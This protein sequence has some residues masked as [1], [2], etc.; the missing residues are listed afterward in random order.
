[1]KLSVVI[2]GYN[3]PEIWWRRCVKSVLVACSAEDEVICVDDGSLKKPM[4]LHDIAKSDSRVKVIMLPSNMGQSEA[5][6]AGLR[7]ANGTYVTFVDSDDSVEP[8]VY[9]RALNKIQKTSSD[10]VVFGARTIWV[11]ER[12]TKVDVPLE[13]DYG[14]VKPSDLKQLIDGCLFEYVWN[15]VYRADFLKRNSIHF[16]SG[17]CPGEDTIFNLEIL[18]SNAKWCS[19][20]Y[21]GY[22]YYRVDGSS[23]SRYQPLAEKSLKYK[24]DLL[25]RYKEKF[26]DGYSVLG[27]TWELTESALS[28]IAWVNAWRRGTPYS[29]FQRMKMRPMKEFAKMLIRMIIRRWFYI[30]PLRKINIRHNFQNAESI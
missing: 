14:I 1:M 9:A 30:V 16:K 22:V 18:L 6:N 19:I 3:T 5:R 27:S 10:V 15:K 17:Y 24:G 21:I 26:E 20:D 12:L 7:F 2:P 28:Q 8:E 11:D 29:L 23:L 4:F 25:R 13:A